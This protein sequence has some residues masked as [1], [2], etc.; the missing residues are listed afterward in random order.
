MNGIGQARRGTNAAGKPG[1]GSDHTSLQRDV[2]RGQASIASNGRI[3]SG[4]AQ[5]LKFARKKD[6]DDN[7]DFLDEDNGDPA[8]VV[9]V[10][11]PTWTPYEDDG[12]EVTDPKEFKTRHYFKRYMKNSEKATNELLDQR[13]RGII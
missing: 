6:E 4:R 2:S 7:W 1:F 5:A 8:E 11:A 12:Y 3:M 13:I 9:D 10:T